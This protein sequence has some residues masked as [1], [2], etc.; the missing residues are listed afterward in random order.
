MMFRDPPLYSGE[1]CRWWMA[2]RR[3]IFFRSVTRTS[4]SAFRL[5]FRATESP[6]CASFFSSGLAARL[7]E[8]AEKT[9][10]RPSLPALL[11]ASSLRKTQDFLRAPATGLL[12]RSETFWTP[13]W[14]LVKP[15]EKNRTHRQRAEPLILAAL[16]L[17][18][19]RDPN[20]PTVRM[21][22]ALPLLLVFIGTAGAIISY[23]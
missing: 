18:S 12:K 13:L 21:P 22:A 7:R 3:P 6:S 11:G 14:L 2:L 20:S 17:T 10:P 19:C 4:V 23:L 16:P 1:K 9:F 8:I 5:G 15:R